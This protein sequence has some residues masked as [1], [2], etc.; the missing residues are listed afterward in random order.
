MKKNRE[1]EKMASIDSHEKQ[2]EEY[3]LIN[4]FSVLEAQA[5]ISIGTITKYLEK[6]LYILSTI[7]TLAPFLGLLGTVYGILVTFSGMSP[8]SGAGSTQHILGGLSL[9]LTTTVVGLLNAIPA[10]IGY[11]ALKNSIT[12]FEHEMERF[13][14]EVLS[15][16]DTHYRKRG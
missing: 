8:D 5:S 14:I 12:D 9:A 16:F 6:H 2:E 4:D 15:T 1:F 7:V 10:L 13:S 11:S 3:L